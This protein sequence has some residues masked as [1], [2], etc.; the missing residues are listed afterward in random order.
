[1]PKLKTK[2]TLKKRIRVTKKGKI[3]KKQT[4][5]GHLKRKWSTNHKFR[6]KKRES[7]DNIGH[8]K[9]IKKLLGKLG[10]GI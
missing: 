9:V 5:I 6:K 10:K 2:K 4:R 1:M 7:Q 3:I 8:K